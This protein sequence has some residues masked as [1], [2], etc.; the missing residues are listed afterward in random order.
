[1][2]NPYSNERYNSARIERI[3][4]DSHLT[5]RSVIYLEGRTID[6]WTE[7]VMNHF[8]GWELACVGRNIS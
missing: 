2:E 4:T 7:Y 5:I 1:M 6:E 8:P 3:S